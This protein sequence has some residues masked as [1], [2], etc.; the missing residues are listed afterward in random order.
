MTIILSLTP[1]ELWKKLQSNIEAARAVSLNEINSEHDGVLV[2][3]PSLNTIGKDVFTLLERSEKLIIFYQ[4]A[5]YWIS[6]STANGVQVSE[7]LEQWE[8]LTIALLDLKKKNRSKVKIINLNLLLLQSQPEIILSKIIGYDI[9]LT[10]QADRGLDNNFHLILAKQAIN[11][12][13][14]TSLNDIF[15]ASC[16]MMGGDIESF[17]DV[18]S[19]LDEQNIVLSNIRYHEDQ[20]K[21]LEKELI[22]AHQIIDDFNKKIEKL[23]NQLNEN[24]RSKQEIQRE[25]ENKILQSNAINKILEYEKN[26]ILTSYEKNYDIEKRLSEI[27][28][29]NK[30]LTQKTHSFRLKNRKAHSEIE[31]LRESLDKK[32][33]HIAELAEKNEANRSQSEINYKKLKRELKK[34][35]GELAQYKAKNAEYNH[36]L[37]SLELEVKT[38]NDSVLWRSSAP[39]RAISNRLTKQERRKQ[40]FQRDLSLI[41]ASR[42]FDADW[43]IKTYPDIAEANLNPAEHYLKFGLEEKRYCSP[44]FDPIW[45]LDKYPDVVDSGMNPLLHFIKYGE[46]EGRLASPKL[47]ELTEKK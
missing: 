6:E 18:Q 40:S 29:E 20:S 9:S 27:N 8:K 23:S 21:L 10:R 38:I 3:T 30:V 4:Q 45:Y 22:T 19:L 35:Q 46:L 14:L 2:L 26:N 13:T 47:L 12:A 1:S 36:K 41:I 5:E 34:T 37:Q 44:F 25:Y 39:F 11:Q 24:S 17:F 43:Y 15:D 7:A 33:W 32:N 16:E 28:T 42:Y 31:L